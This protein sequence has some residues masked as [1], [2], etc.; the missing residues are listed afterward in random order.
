MKKFTSKSVPCS[1]RYTPGRYKERE[2]KQSA[3][4]YEYEGALLQETVLKA[5]DPD[6]PNVEILAKVILGRDQIEQLSVVIRKGQA[7]K[8]IRLI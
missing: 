3:L 7:S 1:S 2:G 5:F 6:D 8:E 4:K